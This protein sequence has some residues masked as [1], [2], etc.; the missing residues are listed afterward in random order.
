MDY[1]V[2]L[3][4]TVSE[5][6]LSAPLE[7]I[8]PISGT[9]NYNAGIRTQTFD[10]QSKQD[11]EEEGREVFTVILLGVTGGAALSQTDSKTTLSGIFSAVIYYISTCPLRSCMNPKS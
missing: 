3:Y 10:I 1:V 5:L 4:S 8:T 6:H 9:L 7:D 2:S 11:I